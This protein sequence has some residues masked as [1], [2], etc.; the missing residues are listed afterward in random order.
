[1]IKKFLIPTMLALLLVT[2]GCDNQTGNTDKPSAQNSTTQQSE[3]NDKKVDKKEEMSIKKNTSD[4]PAKF[5]SEVKVYFPNQDGTKLIAVTR[6]IKFDNESE[7]YLAVLETLLEKPSEKKLV[8]IFPKGAKI[9]SVKI[10]KDVAIVDFDKSLT[11]N[12]VGGSTGEEFLVGSVVNTLTEFPEINRVKFLMGG[13]EIET[14]AGHM[15]LSQP[16][17]RMGNLLK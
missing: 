2:T 14:L 1:M 4:A 6:K 5:S 15:D 7:K 3:N 16:V 8:G 13:Q 9:S 17:K 10:D 11:R 12:F